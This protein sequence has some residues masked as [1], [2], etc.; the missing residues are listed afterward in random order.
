M[1][2][3]L[4][5]SC[6]KNQNH[7][8]TGDANRTNLGGEGVWNIKYQNNPDVFKIEVSIFVAGSVTVSNNCEHSLGFI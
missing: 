2:I 5:M 6:E 4:D 8:L 7:K 3:F 1:F